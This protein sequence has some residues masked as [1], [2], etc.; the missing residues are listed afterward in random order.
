M[1]GP[2]RQQQPQ[3]RQLLQGRIPRTR[4]VGTGVGRQR[5]FKTSDFASIRLWGSLAQAVLVQESVD[6]RGQL[7]FRPTRLF[8]WRRKQNTKQIWHKHEKPLV[9]KSSTAL[10]LGWLTQDPAL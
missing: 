9:I 2:M 8:A 6:F 4:V 7:F 1:A 5:A 10:A 3:G